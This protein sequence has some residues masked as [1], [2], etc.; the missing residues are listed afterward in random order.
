MKKRIPI[1]YS[2]EQEEAS[3]REKQGNAT[4]KQFILEKLIWSK[5]SV[6]VKFNKIWAKSME[7]AIKEPNEI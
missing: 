1:H 7:R 6:R 5:N 3:F 4:L 2:S